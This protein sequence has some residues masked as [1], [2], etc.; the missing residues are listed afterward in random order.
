M[1]GLGR[2]ATISAIGLLLTGCS[3][4]Y[5]YSVDP[6]E[7]V[8]VES[9][10]KSLRCEMMTFFEVNRLRTAIYE[11]NIDKIDFK[12]NFGNYAY[13]DIDPTKYGSIDA[14]FKT[15]DTLGACLYNRDN[16]AVGMCSA[17]S[18]VDR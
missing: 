13:L 7:T 17:G 10:L 14:T 5:E 4:L 8:P 2:Y 1:W 16:R 3:T 12:T 11:Y 6:G 15:I 9:V 18:K